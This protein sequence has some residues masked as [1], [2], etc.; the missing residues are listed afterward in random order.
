MNLTNCKRKAGAEVKLQLLIATD[1]CDYADHLSNTLAG[2]HADAI[3]VSVCSSLENLHE[4][5]DAREFDVALLEATMIESADMQ[6]I[7][8]P[9]LLW[10]E[11]GNIPN[12]PGEI[13]KIRKYQRI[14]TM[15]SSIL[16]LYA[17]ETA[18]E[19]DSCTKRAQITAVWSPVGGA[20]KTTTALAYSAGKAS[21]GKQVMYLNL[22]P[23]SSVSAYFSETGKSVS[24][25]FEMLEIGKGNIKM[26][27]RSI[28]LQDNAS[29]ITYFCRPDNFDDMNI[30]T[31]ENIA[32]LIDACSEVTDE[33]V[34][35]MSSVCDERTRK[36]FE[37]ADRI[38]LVTDTT[39]TAQIKFS[40][41]ASQHNT[42]QR[43]KSKAAL[44]ANKGAMVNESLVDDIICLPLVQ[45]TDTVAVYKT[46]SS[47]KFGN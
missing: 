39:H 10:S 31:S 45:S 3:E 47:F 16:E 23:F 11:E 2:D 37:H 36:V 30:L 19:C 42:F 27:I 32:A 41:F 46:L 44:V 33:L 9:L 25:V 17:G 21:E 5:L 43:I 8:L 24:S 14:S 20:G 35:D 7:H 18:S 1:D 22:E 15:V 13:K 38:L 12:I 6:S 40:Q 4:H 28:R 26:L 29:E 34:I